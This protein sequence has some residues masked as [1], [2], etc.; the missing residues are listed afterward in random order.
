MTS[1]ASDPAGNSGVFSSPLLRW[2]RLNY[3]DGRKLWHAIR[4]GEIR[5]ICGQIYFNH[6][7][8]EFSGTKPVPGKL[9]KLCVA[10]LGAA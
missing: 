9:C 2:A 5:S 3:Q 6:P 10:K 7:R 8:A 4:G 1:Q